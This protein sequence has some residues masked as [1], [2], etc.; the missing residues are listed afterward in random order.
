MSTREIHRLYK[1]ETGSSVGPGW[2]FQIARMR[3]QWVL[4]ISDEM[5]MEVFGRWGEFDV[6]D[7]DYVEWLERKLSELI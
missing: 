1:E 6:P 5:K 2:S 3:G 7:L 4:D